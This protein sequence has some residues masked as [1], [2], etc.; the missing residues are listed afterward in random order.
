MDQGFPKFKGNLSPSM[1]SAIIPMQHIAHKHT[2]KTEELLVQIYLESRLR[3]NSSEREFHFPWANTQAEE[4]S[5]A[6]I[7]GVHISMAFSGAWRGF[8]S[9]I[10]GA[11][12]PK[13]ISPSFSKR[14]LFSSSKGWILLTHHS[15]ESRALEKPH[16]REA[17]RAAT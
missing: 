14:P 1:G 11:A 4:G 5:N 8:H 17:F 16:Q 6:D 9:W 15:T 3:K 2:L 13:K 10:S 12:W 7:P